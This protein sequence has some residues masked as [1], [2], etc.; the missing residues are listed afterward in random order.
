M[1]KI[2]SKNFQLLAGFILFLLGANVLSLL[3]GI[4]ISEHTKNEK[5]GDTGH[6]IPNFETVIVVKNSYTRLAVVLLALLAINFG[7]LAF[8][9][10]TFKITDDAEDALLKKLKEIFL[11]VSSVFL[12]PFFY[13]IYKR[14]FYDALM[15]VVTVALSWGTFIVT[16][17]VRNL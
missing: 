15:V 7:T 1:I 14:N 10:Y 6:M 4:K 16:R 8:L 17:R 11:G 2:R 13:M 3:L 5:T 9:M 12:V